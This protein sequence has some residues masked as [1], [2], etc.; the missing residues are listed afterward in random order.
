MVLFTLPSYSWVQIKGVHHPINKKFYE[1][2]VLS[3]T[4][5]V[6]LGPPTQ[7]T[8]TQQKPPLSLCQCRSS[9]MHHKCWRVGKDRSFYQ[10]QSSMQE[11]V[12]KFLRLQMLPTSSDRPNAAP[13]SDKTN[14]FALLFGAVVGSI[15]CIAPF[16]ELTFHPSYLTE[17]SRCCSPCMWIEPQSIPTIPLRWKGTLSRPW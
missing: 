13:G 17:T 5:L 2:I 4:N 8:N 1:D 14:R 10:E 3:N 12:M 9:T 16:A 6:T 7:Y 11:H 15:G